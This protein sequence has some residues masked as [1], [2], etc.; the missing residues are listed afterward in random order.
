MQA[1][2]LPVRTALEPFGGM[3]GA[4]VGI[5]AWGHFGRM[6]RTGVGRGPSLAE[7]AGWLDFAPI[8]A[9]IVVGEGKHGTCWHF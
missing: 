4:Q 8:C 2:R 3:A 5:G 7:R 6:A 9:I 1:G